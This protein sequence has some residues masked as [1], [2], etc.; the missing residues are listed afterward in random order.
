MTVLGKKTWAIA[1][2]YI[3][4]Q[5]TGFDVE[6]IRTFDEEHSSTPRLQ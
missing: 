3:P 5:S 1:E 2:G 4:S 6:R